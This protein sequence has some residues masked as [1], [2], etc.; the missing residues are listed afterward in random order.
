MKDKL[1]EALNN[2]NATEYQ[3]WLMIKENQRL[4]DMGH[5][6]KYKGFTLEPKIYDFDENLAREKKI[7][8]TESIIDKT[9]LG[10]TALVWIPFYIVLI[11]VVV[12]LFWSL[13]R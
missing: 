2:G 1:Q 13:F 5:E 10:W 12:T 3:K 7:K 11:I 4:R 8:K 6:S 9:M